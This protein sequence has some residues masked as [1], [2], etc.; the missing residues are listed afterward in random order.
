MLLA[1]ILGAFGAHAIKDSVSM[2][3]LDTWQTATEYQFYH[4]LGLIG[5][6]IWLENK[7]MTRLL[8]VC[9][10]CMLLG[11]LLFSGSLYAL[12]LSANSSWGMVTPIGGLF[13]IVG[14]LSWIISTSFFNK[15]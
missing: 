1:V 5:L 2:L 15:K 13:F 10:V 11:I 8:R 6:G 9:A 4:S 7:K 12:V 14:W 3:H